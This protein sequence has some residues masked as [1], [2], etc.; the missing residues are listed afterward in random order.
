MSWVDA[1]FMNPT[2]QERH[3]NKSLGAK[4]SDINA[5]E[6]TTVMEVGFGGVNA[7]PRNGAGTPTVMN[8]RLSVLGQ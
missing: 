1:F 8:Y 5:D 7:P 2:E 4:P 6:N 3:L